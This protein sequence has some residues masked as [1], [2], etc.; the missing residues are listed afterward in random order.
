[1]KLNKS[2]S[3]QAGMGS[4][5]AFSCIAAEPPVPNLQSQCAVER[6]PDTCSLSFAFRLILKSNFIFLELL[7]IP[8]FFRSSVFLPL[9]HHGAPKCSCVLS[10]VLVAGWYRKVSGHD[11]HIPAADSP[12]CCANAISTF[13]SLCHC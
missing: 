8:L 12:C 2:G 5:D 13:F 10:L 9:R 11:G 6:H 4:R 1:M 7:L 3:E